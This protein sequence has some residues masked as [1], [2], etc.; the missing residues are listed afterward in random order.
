MPSYNTRFIPNS[1]LP[2]GHIREHCSAQRDQITTIGRKQGQQVRVERYTPD[3][4]ALLDLALYTVVKLHDEEPALVFVGYTEPESK[5][6][7]LRDRLGL[8]GVEPFTGRIK[9]EVPD[10]NLTDDDAE[11]RGEFVERL[12]DNGQNQGLIVIAPHGGAIERHTDEQAKRV[13]E[14]LASKGASVWLC[15][16]FK[17]NGGAFDRWHITSTDI[18]DASFPKL[19][20]VIDRDFAYAVAF[21]GWSEDFICIGGRA[22][23]GVKEQIKTAIINIP[24]LGIEVKTDLE[25]CPEG[26]NGND[27]KNIVN[28]LGANGIHIEQSSK[29]RTS[30]GRKIADAVADV[31]SPKI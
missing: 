5:K 10:P 24:N 22:P 3:G 7:D 27:P 18:S 14:R 21:H 29:A 31:I 16:G 1:C 15:K 30:F 13:G 12:T 2:N 9:S 6:H 11:K 19:K 23:A 25:D 26:F 20:T 28:R 17:K 4:L 8:S